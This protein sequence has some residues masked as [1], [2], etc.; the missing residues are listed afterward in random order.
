MLSL[1]AIIVSSPYKVVE[2]LA[3]LTTRFAAAGLPA[4]FTGATA[5][6]LS[7]TTLLAFASARLWLPTRSAATAVACLLFLFLS[8]HDRLLS[9]PRLIV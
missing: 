7:S 9:F 3:S 2:V 8:D 4:A 1:S 5:A 6:F